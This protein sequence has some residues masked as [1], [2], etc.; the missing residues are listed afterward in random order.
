MIDYLYHV[1]ILQ[2]EVGR[3]LDGRSYSTQLTR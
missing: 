2:A 1:L 3:V